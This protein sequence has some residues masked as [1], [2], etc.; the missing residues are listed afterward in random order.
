MS[1]QEPPSG[2]QR[3]EENG[4]PLKYKD[5]VPPSRRR[6]ERFA[7]EL[8]DSTRSSQLQKK[9][10]LMI[11]VEDKTR[12]NGEEGE[13]EEEIYIVRQ[14]YGY[15]SVFFSIV[16]TLI[17]IVM[18]WQC[19]IAPLNIN[20]MIGPYPDALSEWGGKNSVLILEDGEWYRLM[21]PILLH[22]G[23]IHL[24]CN[25]AVQ[26][27]TGLLFEREWGS[28]RWLIIYLGSALGSSI[29]SVI[30]MPNAVS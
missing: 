16:Q 15:L 27:E 28:V 18:M 21:T 4:E 25:V 20:P 24:F 11:D 10:A 2:F 13:E 6:R 8:Q 29:L 5:F 14:D 17:L 26:L 22:A 7:D 1:Q 19:G 12:Y 30:I 3:M 9:E 23:I